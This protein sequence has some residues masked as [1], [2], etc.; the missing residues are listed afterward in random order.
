MLCILSYWPLYVLKYLYFVWNPMRTFQLCYIR[1]PFR[2]SNMVPLW[3][4]TKKIGKYSEPYLIHM[5]CMSRCNWT[6]FAHV[7]NDKVWCAVTGA[8]SPSTGRQSSP[9]SW[10]IETQSA[11]QMQSYQSL[12]FRHL[13]PPIPSCTALSWPGSSVVHGRSLGH[14]GLASLQI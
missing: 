11:W 3:F 10:C 4:L 14:R 1:I 5:L 9:P 2:N 8:D 12:W 7:Y 13:D 6:M